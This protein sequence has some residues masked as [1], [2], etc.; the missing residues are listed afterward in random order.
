M[1]T[2][3]QNYPSHKMTKALFIA[4][5]GNIGAGKS[6]LCNTLHDLRSKAGPCTL[7]PEPVD[8]PSFRQLL[9]LFYKDPKR[10]AFAFQMHALKERFNQHTLASELVNSHTSVVQDR[11]I[12]AD[13]CFGITAHELGNM[14]TEEWDIYAEMFG[15]LKRFLRYPD[16]VVYLRVLPEVCKERM[17]RRKR[18]EEAGVPLD[19]LKRLHDQHEMFIEEMSRYTRVLVIDSSPAGDEQVSQVN[20]AIDEIANEDRRFMRDFRKL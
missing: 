12:Y 4:V 2:A 19:Y 8:K 1:T 13:G 10:W 16:V 11:S 15:A 9:G 5:E 14:V 7:M 6:T 20:T 17:D 18:P 3:T